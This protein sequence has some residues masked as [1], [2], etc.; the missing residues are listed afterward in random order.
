MDKGEPFIFPDEEHLT[1][2]LN[3]TFSLLN[4]PKLDEFRTVCYYIGMSVQKENVQATFDKASSQY[5]EMC[6]FFFNH[7]GKELVKKVPNLKRK[8][9]LEVATGRGAVLF[10]L[11][12]A[13][14]EIDTIDLSPEMV[15]LTEVEAK[16]RG[17]DDIRF[18]VMDAE[19]L[20]F[21]DNS[22]DVVI[23]GFAVFFC[24]SIEKVLSEFRRVLK[25]GGI[26]ALSTWGEDSPLD[27]WI[28]NVRNQ[29]QKK[30]LI[31]NPL[32]TVEQIETALAQAKLKDAKI[33][34]E[35][36]IFYY[37]SPE[38]WW[39]SLYTHGTRFF[40]DQ[41]SD[42]ELSDVKERAIQFSRQFVKDQ[43]L[44]EAFEVYYAVACK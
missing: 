40:L 28:S 20:E 24:E 39:D 14:A 27:E 21:E 32:W 34:R 35:K 33:Y 22:F 15:R 5:D 25:P 10:P 16:R 29:M 11:T 42:K 13:G 23:C 19:K 41:L 1:G 9:V 4:C 26:I 43:G 31:G 37:E 17:Y 8:K 38:T 36:K 7:F 6:G 2:S 44:E 30:Q 18:H 12:E 3:A